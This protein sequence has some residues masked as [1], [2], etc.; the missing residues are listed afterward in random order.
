MSVLVPEQRPDKN[1]HIVTRHVR[2]D[3]ASGVTPSGIPAPS[4]VGQT[5]PAFR[6]YKDLAYGELANRTEDKFSELGVKM[7]DNVRKLV[8]AIS[9]NKELSPSAEKLYDLLP[10]IDADGLRSLTGGQMKYLRLGDMNYHLAGPEA[11]VFAIAISAYEYSREVDDATIPV[12]DEL[13]TKKIGIYETAANLYGREKVRC[14]PDTIADVEGHYLMKTLGLSSD[15][16]PSTGDY[17]RGL[18]KL[19][20]RR[21]ELKPYLPL[22]IALHTAYPLGK[23]YYFNDEYYLWDNID[24]IKKYP[25]DRIIAIA[26]E[27][28]KRG[29]FDEEFAA[30]VAGSTS[31][32]LND[33]LL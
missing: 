29:Q 3:K 31:D 7:E 33:G 20:A 28:I 16:F 15:S 6:A 9:S 2:A 13:V 1:G 12:P 23:S 11:Q 26:R 27:T 25:E 17:Y 32:T 18:T 22:M 10:S 21:E 8:I 19:N 14:T 5:G 24:L 4:L 30:E